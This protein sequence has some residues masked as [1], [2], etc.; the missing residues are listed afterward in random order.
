LET[1][2][3]PSLSSPAIAALIVKAG[4]PHSAWHGDLLD[5]ADR[6]AGAFVSLHV[7]SSDELRGCIGTTEGNEANVLAEIV[8]N[9]VSAASEDP[10][11]APLAPEELGDLHISVDVL[12][13]A[14]VLSQRIGLGDVH[15]L[16]AD[17]TLDA[18]RYGVIVSQGWRRGLLLPAL[19]GVD[20]PEH[21][22][23][24]ALNKAGIAASGHFMLSRFEVVRYK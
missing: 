8:R 5:L 15:S 9:A 10:R 17:G 12:G 1:G 24:I 23:A 6:K 13:T 22:V 14:E 21:Q 18:Q 19:D 7:A 16:A 3:A 4:D 11:F 2:S 20:T